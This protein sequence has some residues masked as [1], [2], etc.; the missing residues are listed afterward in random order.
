MSLYELT[1]ATWSRIQTIDLIPRL[2]CRDYYT[3]RGRCVTTFRAEENKDEIALRRIFKWLTY[4]RK[5]K[6]LPQKSTHKYQHHWSFSR[7]LSQ[8]LLHKFFH[9][10][11]EKRYKMAANYKLLIHPISPYWKAQ[12][13]TK[14][15]DNSYTLAE[16]AHSLESAN[17]GN[18]RASRHGEVIED[19]WTT[20]TKM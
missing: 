1:Y 19:H 6:I 12:T 2:N 18:T 5:L 13:L 7:A 11:K 4:S 15:S 8:A 3:T 10:K 16:D 17:P 14:D 9:W 20:M